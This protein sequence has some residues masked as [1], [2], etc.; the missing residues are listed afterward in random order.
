MTPEPAGVTPEPGNDS[1]EPGADTPEPGANA[2]EPAAVTSQGETAP[3]ARTISRGRLIGVNVLIGFTTLLLIVGMFSI[4]A[5]RLLFNPDNWSNT[6]TQLLQNADIRSATAN[7]VVDQLYANVNV[8][9][10]IRQGLPPRLAPLADPA[11]GALRNAAVQGTE[12][13]LSRPR[14]QNLWAQANRAADQTFIN[15]VNGGKGVVSTNNGAV[16][17]NLGAILENV[18]A[19]LG[20]PPGLT[21]KLPPNIATLTVFKSHQLKTVQNAAAMGQALRHMAAQARIVG[22]GSIR[23][24][25]R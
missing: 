7:Y 5:N 20:L 19:R 3:K 9:A 17:L 25:A 18:A 24:E 13:A 21:S 10:L 15:V 1:P 12:L 14:V 23:S 16:T 2:P 8:A 6:S 11:A 22:L 4:W